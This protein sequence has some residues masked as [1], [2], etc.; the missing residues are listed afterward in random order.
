MITRWH[1]TIGAYGFILSAFPTALYADGLDIFR[2]TH[3]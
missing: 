3:L 1:G 2:A